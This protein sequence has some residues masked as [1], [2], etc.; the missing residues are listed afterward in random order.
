M[1]RSVVSAVESGSGGEQLRLVRRGGVPP[2]LCCED[3]PAESAPRAVL[4]ADAAGYFEGL[5]S[6]RGTAWRAA[7]SLA[8]RSF[9]DLEIDEGAPDH[10]T[11]S[12]TRRLIDVTTLEANAA[13][14][15]IVRRDTG[16]S[17]DEFLKGLAKAS[18]IKTPT[19][20]ALARLDRRRK[21]KAS[22][23]DWTSPSEPFQDA[24]IDL[25]SGPRV[26][27]GAEQGEGRVDAGAEADRGVAG[28]PI[29]GAGVAVDQVADL[30][31][32]FHE[33]VGLPE[34]QHG[35]RPFG[36]AE[37]G[38]LA[39]LVHLELPA[40]HVA[41]RGRSRI[42]ARDVVPENVE[43][44]VRALAR[45][46]EECLGASF[47]ARDLHR[48]QGCFAGGGLKLRL[49]PVHQAP[50][51]GGDLRGDRGSVAV[52]DGQDLVHAQHLREAELAVAVEVELSLNGGKEVRV[53]Q[54]ILGPRQSPGQEKVEGLDRGHPHRVPEGGS[55]RAPRP[56]V[57]GEAGPRLVMRPGPFRG[58]GVR[59]H[60][61]RPVEG[62]GPVDCGKAAPPVRLPGGATAFR[63]G[64]PGVGARPERAAEL[65]GICAEGLRDALPFAFDEHQAH[66]GR[67]WGCQ[68]TDRARLVRVERPARRGSPDGGRHP[69]P[70]EAHRGR[71][72]RDRVDVALLDGGARGVLDQHEPK[73]RGAREL[74]QG[75]EAAL[76]LEKGL[77]GD[78]HRPQGAH[79]RRPVRGLA[80]LLYR[81][82]EQADED[83]DDGDDDQE[84]D[85]GEP[86]LTLHKTPP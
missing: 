8:I 10:T 25:D 16:A 19:R 54:E 52:R 49:Q 82:K 36:Q 85:E 4:P 84:L 3:G 20:E 45:Q 33:L 7:D 60:E 24:D 1:M 75:A 76:L 26:R 65:G 39:T 62:A 67:T 43:R 32:Q 74:F 83:R 77:L 41:R 30:L 34:A 27:A 71:R 73:V 15:S 2:V 48:G 66:P 6:E 29:G 78:V 53:A 11:I 64:R 35:R 59:V 58:Q 79:R 23:D 47:Q 44:R 51:D 69:R 68:L 9:L 14:R 37:E 40:R 13:M 56:G 46:I 38:R 81:G 72:R 12:R 31:E 42:E 17:Y 18:G 28:H 55:V 63:R 61:S 21:K 70:E 50:D 22:N 86:A 57:P 5:G 80:H